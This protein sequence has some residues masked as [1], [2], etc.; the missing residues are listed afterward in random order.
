MRKVNIKEQVSK[1]ATVSAAF[2]LFLSRG[3]QNPYVAQ[4]GPWLIP[5]ECEIFL[6]ASLEHRVSGLNADC[7]VLI[8][9]G[10]S[11]ST[12][13]DKTRFPCSG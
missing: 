12:D 3:I 11:Q 9:Q 2:D 13:T 8:G 1:G 10:S 7:A 6:Q 5:P 4:S